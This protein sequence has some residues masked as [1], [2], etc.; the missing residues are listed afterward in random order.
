MG[1]EDSGVY[2]LTAI[3]A[4]IDGIREAIRLNWVEMEHSTPSNAER[5][6]IRANVAYLVQ[7][8]KE[9]LGRTESAE[10]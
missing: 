10:Q 1:A 8:L 3:Q 4:E 2:D 7:A 9:L 5:R 6:A